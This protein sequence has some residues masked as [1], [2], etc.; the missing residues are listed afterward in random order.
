VTLIIP[1]LNE[2]KNLP[3]VL[4]ALGQHVDEIVLVDGGSVDDTAAVARSLRPDVRV[5][6]QTRRGKGNALACGLAASTGDVLVMIDA[7]GSMDADEIP[8]FVHA[9]VNGAHYVKGS[10]ALTG[11]GSDDLTLL[12][13]LGNRT[14]NGLVNALYGTGFTDLCYGFNAIRREDVSALGLPPVDGDEP[15]WGDGFE[16]ETLLTLRALRADLVICE[17]PSYERRRR[18]GASNLH[19]I[20][21]GGRVLRTIMREWRHR[22]LEPVPVPEDAVPVPRAVISL[23][24]GGG[25]VR[26]T[27]VGG[28]GAEPYARASG[29]A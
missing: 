17:V 16:I 27:A 3:H 5:V 15:M 4:P 11:G 18:H 14:L 13:R 25:D 9:V 21:D 26:L 19:P 6:Q 23:V 24:S 12:R 10:R 28:V 20:R 22:R 1:A 7:D 29:N 2:A 8:R